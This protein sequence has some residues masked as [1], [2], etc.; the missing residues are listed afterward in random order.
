MK[1]GTASGADDPATGKPY[2][3]GTEEEFRLAVQKFKDGQK[4]AIYFFFKEPRKS[5]SIKETEDLLKVQKF[6]TEIQDSGWVHTFPDLADKTS[7]VNKIHQ[8][9]NDWVWEVEQKRE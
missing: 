8:V 5:T 2:G 4:I 1:Y 6:K 7:F 3:S 9:L